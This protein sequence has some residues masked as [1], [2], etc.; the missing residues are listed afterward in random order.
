MEN[1][2]EQT[3]NA[4]GEVSYTVR[5]PNNLTVSQKARLENAGSFALTAS[6][7]EASGVPS[8]VN[9]ESIRIGSDIG[10]S[11]IILTA[12][13]VPAIANILDEQFKLQILGKRKDGSA[14]V[15]RTVKLVINEGFTT[16][17]T[18]HCTEQTTN[19]NCV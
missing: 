18:I 16:G 10:Q 14:A 4:K 9:S 7:T 8:T 6:I 17:I 1:N 12:Q 5:V 3:T 2:S 13:S 11:D 19:S 15:G